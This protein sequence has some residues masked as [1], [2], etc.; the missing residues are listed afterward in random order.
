MGKVYRQLADPE[1]ARIDLIRVVDETGE[2][3]LYS[4]KAF[5]L[6]QSTRRRYEARGI[7]RK[8]I[9]VMRVLRE[10]HR[11]PRAWKGG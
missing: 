5:A 11:F 3:Y 4:A 8:E 2:D 1:S 6:V 7:G 10:S 9:K